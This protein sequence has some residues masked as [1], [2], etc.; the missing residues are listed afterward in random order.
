MVCGGAYK[1]KIRGAGAAAVPV[2]V[3]RQLGKRRR[4]TNRRDNE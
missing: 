1:G 2:R 3:L 4:L